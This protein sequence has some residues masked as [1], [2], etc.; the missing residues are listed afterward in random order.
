MK[1]KKAFFLLILTAA[2]SFAACGKNQEA[3]SSVSSASTI[4]GK[5]IDAG[6]VAALCPTGWKSVG[7]EDLE[8]SDSESIRSD[9]LRFVKDG[10]SS[11]D[12]YNNAYIEITYYKDSSS[13][14]S[15]DAQEWYENVNELEKKNYGTLTWEGYSAVSMGKSFVYLETQKDKAYITAT[16][17]TQEGNEV[18]ASLDDADAQAILASI[19]IKK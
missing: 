6:E 17:W 7:V 16:L 9:A 8:A 5:E 19:T 4:E 10:S 15:V 12:I 14:K 13:F 18:S 11:E 2:L 3:A 1:K